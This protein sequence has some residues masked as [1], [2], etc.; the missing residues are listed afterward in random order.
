MTNEE[1]ERLRKVQDDINNRLKELDRQLVTIRLSRG[2]AAVKRFF[3]KICIW[4]V[5]GNQEDDRRN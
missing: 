2:I 4:I 1:Q 3:L 5:G